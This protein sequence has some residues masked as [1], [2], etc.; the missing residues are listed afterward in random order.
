MHLKCNALLLADVFKKF[1]NRCAENHDLRPSHYLSA[2]ALTLNAMLSI[3][4]FQLNL[5]SDV[6]MYLFIQKGMRGGVSYISRRCSKASD[7]YLTS[8][9]N[10]Y[11]TEFISC[12][13]KNNFYG[14]PISRSLP[15]NG[16]KI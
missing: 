7:K 10:E 6:N 1:R 12:L 11:P 16:F 2:A 13:N 4:K 15:T 3:T 9:D 8:Y 14:Y 5:I